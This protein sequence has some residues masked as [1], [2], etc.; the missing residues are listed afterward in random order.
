MGRAIT[1]Q[2]HNTRLGPMCRNRKERAAWEDCLNLYNDVVSH[3][4]TTLTNT[5]CTD[6]DSQTWLSAAL[7]DLDTC[8]A[9]FMDLGLSSS[10]LLPNN[11]NNVS[12]LLSNALAL[13]NYNATNYAATSSG[14]PSWVSADNRRLLQSV[15]SA[16]LVVAK[17]GSGNFRT[18][19]EAIAA[20]GQ[21]QR[22]GR[23]FVIRI[24]SGV[25]K[26]NVEI[27]KKLKNIMLV[28]DGMKSTVITG[29]RSVGGGSTTFNSA[30]VVVTGDR[31]IARDITFRNT[32][33]AKNHQA[34][35]LRSGSDL[36]AFYKCSFEGYQDT[37]YVHSNRQFYRECYIYGTVDF[38]FG[39]AAAV[40][41]NCMIYAR[42]PMAK[43]KIT[44]T[45][46][47][48]TD[49]NQNT[50]ISIHNSRVMAGSDLR[51][52]LGSFKT[53]LGRPWKAYS[54]TVVMQTFLDSLVEP[55][56]WLEWDGDFGLRT[57][58]YGEY[59][60]TGPGS[61][62]GRRVT[63]RGYRVISSAN[64]AVRFS[65]GNFIAGRAWIPGTGVPFTAGL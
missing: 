59:R 30:T 56:G 64:E 63:W 6:F 53:Y 22:G 50:G 14:F 17:D 18:V 12:K 5:K 20:A 15:P 27:G 31:F 54:R 23:R 46:Q 61:P 55:A 19:K 32:A 2:A 33:G 65:V 28:G 44:V 24:K 48:R 1:A 38:I 49:P 39:N 13:S 34:V 4:N 9:G 57:L 47:G 11:H 43:Q 60:N 41:Q 3:L 8:H 40:L 58:Y 45:A 52:V 21:R 16:D 51:P 36:S 25:Y 35:A 37:L 42:R 29:S 7:T 26:E 10:P 62:T